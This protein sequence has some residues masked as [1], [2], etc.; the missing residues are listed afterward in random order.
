VA[1]VDGNSSGVHELTGAEEVVV[2]R[3]M[4]I[5]DGAKVRTAPSDW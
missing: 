4:E 5:G 3:Q 2:G 1:L